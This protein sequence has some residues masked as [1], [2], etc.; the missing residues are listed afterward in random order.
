MTK[1]KKTEGRIIQ[2]VERSIKAMLLFLEDDSELGI[3]DFSRQLDLPKPTIYSIVNTL[4][5]YNVLEQN[6]D[7]SKYHLGP[8]HRYNPTMFVCAFI[9]HVHQDPPA[10]PWVVK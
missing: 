2:S 7:N 6:P 4:T 5:A 3:K 1:N 8:A 10:L 9:P